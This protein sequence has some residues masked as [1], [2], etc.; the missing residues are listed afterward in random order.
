VR[1]PTTYLQCVHMNSL[2][3]CEH[4]EREQREDKDELAQ[5]V[6]RLD[7]IVSMYVAFAL[8]RTHA[9]VALTHG[10]RQLRVRGKLR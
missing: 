4:D 10:H 3:E 2:R 7:Q 8:G 1:W 6:T 9:Q 5:D